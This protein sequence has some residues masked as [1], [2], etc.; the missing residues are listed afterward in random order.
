MQAHASGLA[1]AGSASVA[2]NTRLLSPAKSTSSPNTRPCAPSLLALRCYHTEAASQGSKQPQL[3]VPPSSLGT[4]GPHPPNTTGSVCPPP[5]HL[6]SSQNLPSASLASAS[7]D[8]PCLP[9]TSWVQQPHRSS[10]G[11]PRGKRTVVAGARDSSPGWRLQPH[12][13]PHPFDGERPWKIDVSTEPAGGGCQVGLKEKRGVGPQTERTAEAHGHGS[14]QRHLPVSSPSL[15]PLAPACEDTGTSWLEV[16][17]LKASRSRQ[18][19]PYMTIPLRC[20]SGLPGSARVPCASVS[21]TGIR[22]SHRGTQEAQS[23]N[24]QPHRKGPNNSWSAK[25]KG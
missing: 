4:P 19:A 3:S 11:S 23:Q 21:H 22:H 9:T 15:S 14:E 10:L 1:A 25:C 5:V 2:Q 12:C 20:G 17:T 6:G 24:K 18:R 16:P 7:P 8:S 13:P